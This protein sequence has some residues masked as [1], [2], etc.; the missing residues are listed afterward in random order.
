MNS[1]RRWFPTGGKCPSLVFLIA[2][3]AYCVP[4]SG[5]NYKRHENLLPDSCEF[6][7]DELWGRLSPDSLEFRFASARSG[8]ALALF[9]FRD[10]FPI[11]GDIARRLDTDAHLRTVHRHHG[12]FHII[13]DAQRLSGAA[14]E[15]QHVTAPGN[16][17]CH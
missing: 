9:A 6:S 15:Y 16:L 8:F 2:L 1:A 10:F 3:S 4:E 17:T 14:S 11:D 12:H 5:T 7:V 13:A